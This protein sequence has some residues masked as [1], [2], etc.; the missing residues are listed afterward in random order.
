MI[1]GME[2]GV[3][4]ADREGVVV[5]VND[6]LCRFLGQPRDRIMGRNILDLHLGGT[7]EGL[8][9]HIERFRA[10][11]G[12][13][14]LVRQRPLRGAEVIFRVQPI[15]REGAYD[16]VLLN[17]INVTEL[18]QARRQAEEANHSKSAFLATMSHEI[19]T[20]MNGVI[21]MTD[22]LLETE[23]SPEQRDSLALIKSSANALLTIINDI[24]DFSK[25]EAGKLTLDSM[26]FDLRAGLGETLQSLAAHAQEKG[27]ELA[28]RV[29]PKVPN[30]LVG[31]PMR[32]R[33]VMLNLVGNAIKFT[34]SGE[35]VVEVAP[36]E[37]TPGA[38]RLHFAVRDT[39]VGIPPEK[40]AAIFNAF[41]QADMSITRQ[42]GGTGLGLAISSQLVGLMGGALGVESQPGQ[43][44][45]FT[46]EA[47]FDRHG[48]DRAALPAAPE[49]AQGL[50][51]LVVD[52]NATARGIVMEML[53][54]WGMEAVE[55]D[56]GPAA[57][58]SLEAAFAAGAPFA[59]A[60]VDT[61]LGPASGFDLA[62][63]VLARPG[64]VRALVMVCSAA[65]QVAEAARCRQLGLENYLSKPVRQSD[66]M[67]AIQT[68]LSGRPSSRRG[69]SAAAPPDQ[70][71]PSRGLLVLLAEDNPVNQKLASSLLERK[72]HRVVVAV[73]GLE[74]VEM[75]ARR[76]FDLALMDV[77]MPEM[78]G[79]TATRLIR[80]RERETGLHLP[81]AAMTAHA[82][83]GDR[84]RCLQAGMDAY[85]SKPINPRELWET[86]DRLLPAEARE[87]APP[88]P[89][90]VPGGD[91]GKLMARFDGDLA[92]VRQLVGL[93]LEE[94]PSMLGNLEKALGAHDAAA[95]A[96]AAHAL[97]GSVGYFEWPAASAAAL[98]LERLG[99]A[100][101][102]A[103]APQ[104]L[105]E[106]KIELE[107]LA[108][109]LQNLLAR[110]N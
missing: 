63:Q 13:A 78:D 62:A 80:Q 98:R 14:P 34:P 71:R 55:A 4:F 9:R 38:A 86:I 96:Q 66:L 88:E 37:V 89:V 101:D 56:D 103:A 69:E 51:V 107:R 110:E 59:L 68:A 91:F 83:P 90:S 65:D 44:S 36:L 85:L 108:L 1:T 70:A 105:E 95:L 53:G 81:I 39:G 106:L 8:K 74:A 40:Q 73:N 72:G 92:L 15:Y 23:L 17:V 87:E 7:L 30:Q 24:L 43:G 21:G 27:L 25:I 84:E 20:P 79:L 52:D 11:P 47:L 104:A 19:R 49:Q 82:M 33:Q 32:L 10:E 31:D 18:V 61:R 54:Q 48:P 28:Y 109:G 2:E 3:V 41:E 35:V 102:L 6:Y 16:G 100:H 64:L 60:L 58:A 45:T 76:R 50:K 67:D 5:E 99:R 97:K 12:S 57:W 22:L 94:Y 29:D 26:E 77:Q 42:Y 93:F 75:S 46:F